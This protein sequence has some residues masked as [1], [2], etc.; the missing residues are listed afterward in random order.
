MKVLALDFDGVISDS[1]PE[2]FWVALRTLVRLGP[3]ERYRVLLARLNE[4]DGSR[5]R[6][7]IVESSL[8]REFLALMPL[9]N[10]AAADEGRQ[11]GDGGERSHSPHG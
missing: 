6:E 11:K 8:Y 5:A 9:G 3:I 2:C 4:L 1:A 7:V 10:R